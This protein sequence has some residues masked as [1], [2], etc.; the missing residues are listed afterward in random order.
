VLKNL[1]IDFAD[2][3]AAFSKHRSQLW[4]DRSVWWGD[5]AE[6]ID[7]GQSIA[8]IRKQHQPTEK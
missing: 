6:A 4:L 7:A 1:I 5:C 8:E 2:F 3:M